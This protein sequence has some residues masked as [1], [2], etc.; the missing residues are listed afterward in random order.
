MAARL[1]ARQKRNSAGKR[2]GPANIQLVGGVAAPAPFAGKNDIRLDVVAAEMGA[3]GTPVPALVIKIALRCAVID[4][5]MWVA[6]A[7]AA[8][9]A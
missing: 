7:G 1:H 9:A 4:P 6:K 8:R 3:D 5:E 2:H